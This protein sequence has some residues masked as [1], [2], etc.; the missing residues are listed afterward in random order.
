MWSQGRDKKKKTSFRQRKIKNQANIL[1]FKSSNCKTLDPD[2][3]KKFIINQ[4]KK[5]VKLK[6]KK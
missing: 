3:I 5:L 2:S 4:F 1:I 6:N